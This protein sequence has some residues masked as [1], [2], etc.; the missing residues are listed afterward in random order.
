MENGSVSMGLFGGSSSGAMKELGEDIAK[1]I[2]AS[3]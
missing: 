1:A 3:W 2:R